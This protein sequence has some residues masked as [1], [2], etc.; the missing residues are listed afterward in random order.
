LL[1]LIAILEDLRGRPMAVSYAD[2][3]PGDQR[4]YVSNV[5]KLSAA[6]GWSP[7]VDVKTGVE[8]L[9]SW[10]TSHQEMLE[11]VRATVAARAGR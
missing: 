6:L 2:W 4:V 3:R 11:S 10:A 5:G 8:R 7:R 9:F 1:D